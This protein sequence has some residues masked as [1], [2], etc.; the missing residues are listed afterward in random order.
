MKPLVILQRIFS[1]KNLI[2]LVFT[3]VVV[4]TLVMIFHRVE[5]WRGARAWDTYRKLAEARGVQLWL[6]DFATPAIP[7][8]Q[9]FAAIPFFSGRFGTAEQKK[10]AE[11]LLPSLSHPKLK[12]PAAGNSLEGKSTNFTEWRDFFVET[13]TISAPT[14]NAAQDIVN[15]VGRFPGI[16]QIRGAASRAKCRFPIDIEKGFALE[17]PH[18]SAFQAAANFLALDAEARLTLGDPA[19]ALDDCL[20]ILRLA[21]AVRDEPYLIALLVRISLIERTVGIVRRGLALGAWK[22]EQFAAI[23]TTLGAQKLIPALRFSMASERA[24]MTTEFNRLASDPSYDGNSMW[25]A[26]GTTP[27]VSWVYPRGWIYMNMVKGNEIHD[28]IAAAYAPVN[29]YEPESISGRP[30]I[31]DELGQLTGI[32]S[33]RYLFVRLLMPALSGVERAT[34]SCQTLISQTLIAIALERTKT[35]AGNYP[36]TL[37]ALPAFTIP[38]DPCDGQPMRYRRTE[39]GYEL[40]SVA[41]N[42]IDEAGK[43][44][45]KVSNRREQPDWLWKFTPTPAAK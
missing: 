31:D 25:Q 22:D 37:A 21:D 1:R 7:E 4:V 2:R 36:D 35:S 19:G 30:G 23:D 14:E 44:D 3:I 17:L 39:T 42:R 13:K 43:Q 26:I 29:G 8:D 24:A 18:L 38:K 11:A 41:G 40:W 9:N 20:L 10:A 12:R 33:F 5:A 15:A 45:P 16:Q 27:A 34:L 28:G 32:D 6:R